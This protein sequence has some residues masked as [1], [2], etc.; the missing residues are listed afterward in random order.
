MNISGQTGDERNMSAALQQERS[1]DIVGS[2]SLVSCVVELKDRKE[3]GR[4]QAVV[5]Y[6]P[7]PILLHNVNGLSLPVVRKM[8]ISSAQ[9]LGIAKHHRW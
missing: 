8:I 1:D 2:C 3:G 7:D 4:Y 6:I 5:H 9:Q